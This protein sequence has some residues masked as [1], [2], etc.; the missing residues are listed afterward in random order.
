MVS[1]KHPKSNPELTQKK[2]AGMDDGAFYPPPATDADYDVSVGA[3][4]SGQ[5]DCVFAPPPNGM[6][7][8]FDLP[9]CLVCGRPAVIQR[10]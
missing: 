5:H 6:G 1:S 7:V 4:D 3:R 10:R 8:R 9:N 2:P